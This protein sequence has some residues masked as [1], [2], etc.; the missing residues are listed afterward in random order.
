MKTCFSF[1]GHRIFSHLNLPTTI[2]PKSLCYF[3]SALPSL[4][5]TLFKASPGDTW[6][7]SLVT[8]F[9]S[10]N[11]RHYE[12]ITICNIYRSP[13]ARF[14]IFFL[15]IH[16]TKSYHIRSTCNYKFHA[17]KVQ[18]HTHTS[19]LKHILYF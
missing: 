2:T 14:P 5:P 10:F 11:P 19:L 16:I 13:Q 17:L 7:Q 9:L 1:D 6:T 15:K 8:N 4:P 12:S 3:N 18:T